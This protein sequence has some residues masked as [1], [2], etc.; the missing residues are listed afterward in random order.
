MGRRSRIDSLELHRM[1]DEGIPNKDIARHFG[2]S[3]PAICVAIKRMKAG[4][5]TVTAVAKAPEVHA[6]HLDTISQLSKINHD[7]NEILDLVMRWS[8]GDD[9]AIRILETQVKRVKWRRKYTD[10]DDPEKDTE[11]DVDEIK[12]KD[13]RELALKAMAEIRN[14][15]RLQLEIYQTLYDIKAAEEFQKEVLTA[16]GEITPD[17]RD[18]IIRRLKENRAIRAAIEQTGPTL[19]LTS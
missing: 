9:E 1:T 15:L 10:D 17:V 18:R 14:Q 16:I 6:A 11:L 7:A 8:R 12:F 4:L 2:V 5:T 3:E 19:Q 13:P